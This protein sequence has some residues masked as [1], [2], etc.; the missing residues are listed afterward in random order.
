MRRRRSYV[1]PAYL[2]SLESRLSP[3]AVV[4]GHAPPVAAAV[5]LVARADQP[6]PPPDPEPDPGP[7]PGDD[8]PIVYPPLPSA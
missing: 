7:F 5:P 2:D 1:F 3:S 8:P 6:L 4:P